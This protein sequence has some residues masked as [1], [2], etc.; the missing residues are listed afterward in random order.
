MRLHSGSVLTYP[1]CC[2]SGVCSL[3]LRTMG[4]RTASCSAPA[5]CSGSSPA[6]G[7][8]LPRCPCPGRAVRLNP[9]PLPSLQGA[10]RGFTATTIGV[11]SMFTINR[12]ALRRSLTFTA[13]AGRKG[14]CTSP[15]PTYTHTP[16]APFQPRPQLRHAERPRLN[17]FG[18]HRVAGEL[19]RPVK[20]LAELAALPRVQVLSPFLASCGSCTCPSRLLLRGTSRVR[21]SASHLAASRRHANISIGEW[22]EC[23]N[24][25]LASLASAARRDRAC[26]SRAGH[27]PQL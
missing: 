18:R 16:H 25:L 4:T 5:P 17:P 6:F 10:R 15:P 27:T 14:P 23:I 8:P 1:M 21:C 20:L 26:S 19:L 13:H 22:R 2:C 24:R 11:T 9:L 7:C 3:S 12:E